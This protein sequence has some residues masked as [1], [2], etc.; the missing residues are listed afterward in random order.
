MASSDHS[1][2]H[3]TGSFPAD[4]MHQFEIARYFEL[5]IGG[6]DIS[7]TNSALFMVISVILISFFSIF[8]VRKQALVPSRMQSLVELSYE[9]VSNM[10]RQNV[11]QEGKKYFPF[12]FTIFM[13]VL[14]LNMLGMMPYSFTVTSHI[15]VTFALAFLIFLLVTIVGFVKHG[16]GFFGYF[17][18]KGVP[19]FMLPLLVVIEVIS[20]FT[21]PISLSVRL[22]A[23]M[24]A[25][26]T[27]LKVFSG[28]V[29]S[30]GFVGGWLPLGVMVAFTGLEILIAFLQAYVFTIL[31]CIYL[32]DSLH[33]H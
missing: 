1:G 29:L 24:M 7:F 30:L 18:P 4:P 5:N 33:M 32:N 15:A 19:V 26:H 17:A 8:F 9:F 10:V 11:G 3:G 31:T 12:I 20:Y 23:N 22:F 25:G 28:F 2:D 27:M 16:F 6:L 14:F 21:R 13:F